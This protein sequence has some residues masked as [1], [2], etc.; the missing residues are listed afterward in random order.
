MRG[1]GNENPLP[2]RGFPQPCK[3]VINRVHHLAK[4]PLRRHGV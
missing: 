4:L 2:F 1:I 3:K